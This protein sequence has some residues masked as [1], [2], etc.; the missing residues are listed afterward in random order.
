MRILKYIV[1]ALSLCILGV[2]SYYVVSSI[3]RNNKEG[4]DT[5]EVQEPKGV[6][7][8]TGVK[9]EGT[10]IE[11]KLIQNFALDTSVSLPQWERI[12]DVSRGILASAFIEPTDVNKPQSS[13]LRATVLDA[14]R[15]IKSAVLRAD[16]PDRRVS[17]L[18]IA[19]EENPQHLAWSEKQQLLAYETVDNDASSD[20]RAKDVYRSIKVYDPKTE[21]TALEIKNAMK[22]FWTPDG[23][24]LVYLQKDGIHA[25]DWKTSADTLLISVADY[26]PETRYLDANTHI[27]MSP[28]GHY[29][30]WTTPATGSLHIF[31]V[32]SWSPFVWKTIQRDVVPGTQFYWPVFSPDSQFI[33]TQAIDGDPLIGERTNA[34]MEIRALGSNTVVRSYPLDDFDFNKLFND[35]WVATS[36]ESFDFGRYF[37][38]SWSVTLPKLFKLPSP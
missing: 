31:E 10:D 8:I 6:I 18:A 38:E 9:K 20:V 30:A 25:R 13:F 15:T 11:T 26:N 34:R 23:T 37:E 17:F 5:Q 16:M 14:D 27:G 2:L 28:D 22:P 12:G 7:V 4:G 36:I 19:I 24:N 21:T 35:T 29:L 33:A 1:V 32:T 3:G